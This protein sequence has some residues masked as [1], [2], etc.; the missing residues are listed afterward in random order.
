VS[1]GAGRS[2]LPGDAALGT[3]G[4]AGTSRRIDAHQH[5]WDLSTGL[6]DWPSAAEGPIFRSFKPDDLAPELA[7]AGIDGTVLVQT[8]DSLADTDS[9]LEIAASHAFVAAVVGWV[10]LTDADA[11]ATELDR[12]SGRLAGIRHLVHR[13]ADP[14]WLLRADIQDGLALLAERGLPFDVVAVYPLHLRLVPIVAARH[15][16]LVLVIDHLAKPPFRREDWDGWVR[17]MRAAAQSPLVFAKVSGLDTAAGAGWTADE[18]RPSLDVALEAFG[19][20]RLLFGSDWP[21]SRL[22]S[23]YG[24]VVAATEDLVARLSESERAAIMGGTATR[25]YRLD[26]ADGADGG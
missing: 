20:D 6:Y 24:E 13:E 2:G 9:M 25:V 19:A 1:D 22:V 4:S 8:T 5:F 14:E 17:D 16:D 18:L 3:G 21:V 10:P 12:W 15:P 11:A 7:A 23:T 26:G